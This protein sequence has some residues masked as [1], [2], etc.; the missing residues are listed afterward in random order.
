M[1]LFSIID[2]ENT[3]LSINFDHS[4]YLLKKLIVI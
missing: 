2:Q 3:H 1:S 4:Q